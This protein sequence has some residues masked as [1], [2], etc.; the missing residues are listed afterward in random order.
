VQQIVRNYT[1]HPK[2]QIKCALSGMQTT[3][4]ASLL[5]DG[6]LDDWLRA[7]A[8]AMSTTS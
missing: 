2:P 4:V 3:H 6:E 8:R 7:R 1:L 5:D